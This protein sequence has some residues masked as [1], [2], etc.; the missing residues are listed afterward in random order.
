[1]NRSYLGRDGHEVTEE[2][3]WDFSELEHLHGG[4]HAHVD[5][6]DVQHSAAMKVG[7]L[8]IQTDDHPSEQK[9]FDEI[10]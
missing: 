10:F 7:D 5:E 9:K 4:L 6:H 1:M 2:R 3:R 8:K